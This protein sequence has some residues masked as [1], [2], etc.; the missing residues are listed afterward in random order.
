[1]PLQPER[2]FD[3]SRPLFV[4]RF[5]V[6]A[7]RHLNVEAEFLWR[8]WAV[9]E[10]RVRQ[11]FESGKLTHDVPQRADLAGLQARESTASAPRTVAPT[12]E[13][14]MQDEDIHHVA[15]TAPAAVEQPAAPAESDGLDAL[16]MKQLRDIAQAEN[17]PFR[18]SRT[19]QREAIRE[20]RNARPAG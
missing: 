5:F 19:A 10:R 18:S 15:V 3:P 16:D 12:V 1:M 14:E 7:G 8:Q 20:A 6:A 2:K 11:L 4:R 9:N 13:Q 17:A